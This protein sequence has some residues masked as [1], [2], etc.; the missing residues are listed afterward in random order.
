MSRR[1]EPLDRQVE[2]KKLMLERKKND[3][4]RSKNKRYDVVTKENEIGIKALP[5]GGGDS[6]AARRRRKKLEAQARRNAELKASVLYKKKTAGFAM[7]EAVVEKP[8]ALKG[9]ARGRHMRHIQKTE[10][11]VVTIE[12]DRHI[13]LL[14]K[15]T[16]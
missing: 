6:G 16:N 2:K 7:K 4:E 12:S 13:D 10:K 3:K 5:K 11:V 8:L 15:G 9:F 14:R 1:K